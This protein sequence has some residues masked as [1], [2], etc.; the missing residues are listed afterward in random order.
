MTR[1]CKN[2]LAGKCV[3]GYGKTKKINYIINPLFV[4]KG[5]LMQE[6]VI[7][8]FRKQFNEYLEKNYKKEFTNFKEDFLSNN[9][10]VTFNPDTLYYDFTDC[11]EE[12]AIFNE[13]IKKKLFM[14]SPFGLMLNIKK[15]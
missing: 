1:L 12:L 14:Q 2:G 9:L 4:F 5:E 3:G 6:E 15:T 11:L 8:I 10:P 13:N 7:H